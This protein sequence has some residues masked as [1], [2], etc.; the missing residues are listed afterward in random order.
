VGNII[1]NNTPWAI[2]HLFGA[3]TYEQLPK[4]LE[5]SINLIVAGGTQPLVTAVE[6]F[7]DKQIQAIAKAALDHGLGIFI[8][9]PAA[10][11]FT[12]L[13]NAQIPA[14][15][16]SLATNGAASAEDVAAAKAAITSKTDLNILNSVA[17]AVKQEQSQIDP[18][19]V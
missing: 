9:A 18:N 12:S 4:V 7:V 8:A 5:V 2:D 10:A 3:G 6:T 15:L 14:I 17:D 11:E 19:P 1:T 13:A 16:D